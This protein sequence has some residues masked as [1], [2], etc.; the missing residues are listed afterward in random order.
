MS[1]IPSFGCRE[2]ISLCKDL[3]FI[4]DKSKGKGGHLKATH[5]TKV[6]RDENG[7][8]TKFITI[9]GKKDYS[10]RFRNLFVKELTY[11]GFS[12]EE[13]LQRL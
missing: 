5:P 3:G 9:R 4:I 10:K 13:I 6:A 11:F 1:S 2:A 7:R 12:E 8:V